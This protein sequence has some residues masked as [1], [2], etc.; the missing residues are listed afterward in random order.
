MAMRSAF[1]RLER[2]AGAT[3]PTWLARMDRRAEWNEPP[4]ASRTSASPYQ[5]SS[6]TVPSVASRSI[7]S[8]SPADVELECTTRSQ[9]SMVSRASEASAKSTPR[10]DATSAL[11][12]STSTIVTCAPGMPA[13][14]RATQH[15][16]IP[17]PT[18]ATLS[19]TR[20]SASQRAFTAVS[21]VPASTARSGGTSS[22]TTDTA[23]TGTT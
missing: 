18:T 3:A 6:T 19:P 2:R 21:T 14:R 7:E 20:G 16:T 22:G 17:P 15:P 13:K 10:A 23:S 5:L 8:W 4:R 9:R 1:V 11:L 12:G